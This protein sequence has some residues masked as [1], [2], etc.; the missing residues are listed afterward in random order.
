MT[1]VS[2]SILNSSQQLVI[3]LCTG[4]SLCIAVYMVAVAQSLS[5]GDATSIYVYIAQLFAPLSFLGTIYGAVIQVRAT[6][7]LLLC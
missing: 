7:L 5:S 6:C 1:Q 3:Q 2:L 4:G